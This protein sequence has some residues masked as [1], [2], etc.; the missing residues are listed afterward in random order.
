LLVVDGDSVYGFGR[1]NQY[2]RNG[3]HVG[4]GSVRYRLYA[5]ATVSKA[6]QQTPGPSAGRV[7]NPR[8]ATRQAP[9]AEKPEAAARAKRRG[10][11]A[12]AE[13]KVACRWSEQIPLQA[14]AMVLCG[15]TLF[16]AGP[17][18]VL[19]DGSDAPAENPYSVDSPN[20]LA[21]QEAALA[22][23]RGALLWAVSTADGQKLRE[24][25]LASPPVFDGMAA[26]GGRLYLCTMD[27]HVHC[28]AGGL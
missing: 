11:L 28:L 5:C 12:A 13:S 9:A 23:K 22:G 15:E 26:A 8:R 4:L 14:R 19:G 27:G 6:A 3:A 17:P 7:G 24:F 1:M 21:E 2:H 18:D 20:V 25:K 10:N 16:V